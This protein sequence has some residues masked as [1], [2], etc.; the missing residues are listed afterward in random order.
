MNDKNRMHYFDMHATGDRV[1][2]LESIQALLNAEMHLHGNVRDVTGTWFND[3]LA[4][5][6]P[7]IVM[8]Y[9][10]N[11]PN[12]DHIKPAYEAVASVMAL[13]NGSRS[14]S[15]IVH[16]LSISLSGTSSLRRVC[17]PLSCSMRTESPPMRTF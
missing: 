2:E 6:K 9:S 4:N 11:C 12:C 3:Q 14:A 17:P 1:R 16:C 13:E 15:W 7:F 5:G 8:F 10:P